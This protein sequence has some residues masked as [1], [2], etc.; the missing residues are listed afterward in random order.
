MPIAR[1]TVTSSSGR[2]RAGSPKLVPQS[3]NPAATTTTPAT[4]PAA[5]RGGRSGLAADEVRPGRA[6]D[7]DRHGRGL[8][9]LR[10]ELLHR[11]DGRGRRI[12]DS[13]RDLPGQLRPNVARGVDAWQARLH[14]R[15]GYQESQRVVLDVFAMIEE[16]HVRLEADEDEQSGDLQRPGL[17]RDHVF[18]RDLFHLAVLTLDLGDGRVGDQLDLGVLA[19]RLDEDGLGAKVLAAVDDVDLLCVAGQKDALLERR[20]A[21]ADHGDLFLLEEGPV[22]HGALRNAAP[23]ELAL[24][25]DAELLGLA[26]RGQNDVVRRVLSV[27][28]L[29]DVLRAA[30]ADPGDADGL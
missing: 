27:L 18:Q 25:R 11:I 8:V 13:R 29:H 30:P 14:R 19:C 23:L 1:P 28:G 5:K 22:T 12:A 24:T 6:V 26:A 2:Y 15:V 17:P 16:L 10:F 21:A 7:V 3:R 20:V 9:L 4:A